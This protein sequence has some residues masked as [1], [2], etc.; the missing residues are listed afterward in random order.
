MPSADGQCESVAEMKR[1][2]RT[3]TAH[4]G[5]GR[6]H[7][8][9]CWFWSGTIHVRH[10]RGCAAA[11]QAIIDLRL[12]RTIARTALVPGSGTDSSSVIRP[13]RPL[14]EILQTSRPTRAG[15]IAARVEFVQGYRGEDFGRDAVVARVRCGLGLIGTPETVGCEMGECAGSGGR[16]LSLDHHDQSTRHSPR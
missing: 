4:A 1:C 13:E 9:H 12:R 7:V 11:A 6:D 14:P 16:R 5:H 2:A 8:R 15:S 3:G 10:R